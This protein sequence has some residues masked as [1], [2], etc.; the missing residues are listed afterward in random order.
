MNVQWAPNLVNGMTMLPRVL[1][2]G[3]NG[4]VID[5]S[6]GA[7]G[8]ALLDCLDGQEGTGACPGG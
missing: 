3:E 8:A 7:F 4:P 1:S 5:T 6:H 2:H